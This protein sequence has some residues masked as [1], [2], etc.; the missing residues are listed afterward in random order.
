MESDSASLIVWRSGSSSGAQLLLPQSAGQCSVRLPATGPGS[1][2]YE[3]YSSLGVFAETRANRAAHSLGL[4]PHAVAH[5]IT[6]FFGDGSERE[7]KLNEMRGPQCRKL[8]K[9]CLN[10]MEY[11]LPSESSQ[12]QLH[13]FKS[14]VMFTTRYPGIRRLFLRCEHVQR[15]GPSLD[16]ISTLWDRSDASCGQEW[17][18]LLHFAAACVADGALALMVEEIPLQCSCA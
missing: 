5:R 11:A 4:G 10:L 12:T 18:F 14:I 17:D 2:L 1:T 3:I 8:K 15:V 9:D 7:V 16:A 6:K 13:T